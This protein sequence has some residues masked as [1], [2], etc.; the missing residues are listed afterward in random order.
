MRTLTVPLIPETP[1]SL[2][3]VI[4]HCPINKNPAACTREEAKKCGLP[5]RVT[6][7]TTADIHRILSSEAY[8]SIMHARDRVQFLFIKLHVRLDPIEFELPIDQ[9]VRLIQFRQ[10]DLA[11]TFITHL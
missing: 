11:D 2:C 9:L 5:L 6:E 10:K 3:P 1:G 4:N 8:R 7:M